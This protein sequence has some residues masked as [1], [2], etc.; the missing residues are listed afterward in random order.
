MGTEQ[1]SQSSSK[2]NQ[3][4]SAAHIAE[5]QQ[6][7]GWAVPAGPAGTLPSTPSSPAFAFI[8]AFIA[9]F[10][11]CAFLSAAPAAT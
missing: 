1:S 11:R 6:K 10:G 9:P 8:F 5:Q 2:H 3:R 4:G 7:E